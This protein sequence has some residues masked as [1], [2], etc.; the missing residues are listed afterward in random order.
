MAEEMNNQEEIQEEIQVS[1][2]V[3]SPEEIVYDE[4]NLGVVT[5]NWPS[6]AKE[7]AQNGQLYLNH[8]TISPFLF[9]ATNAYF[10]SSSPI[11]KISWLVSITSPSPI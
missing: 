6:E 10:L 9:F 8:A 11:A 4:Y 1:E 2:N 7:N 3:D 5:L